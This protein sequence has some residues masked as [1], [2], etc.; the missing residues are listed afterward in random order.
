MPDG[1]SGGS[2]PDAEQK[3]LDKAMDEYPYLFTMD[4]LWLFDR[5]FPGAPRVARLIK[6][7]HV[8]IRVKSDIPL[9]RV[10][11]LL[12]RSWLADLA[13]GEGKDRVTVR[14]RVIEYWVAVEGQDVPEMFCLIT[15]LLDCEAYP[16]R[17]LAVAYRWRWNG[18]EPGCAK[19][20]ASS[21][22]PAPPPGR[23]SAPGPRC[24]SGRNS[25]PGHWPANWSATPPT[26]Q[27]RPAR[28][29]APDSPSTPAS[30]PSPPPAA[31]PSPAS[32]RAPRLRG[33]PPPRSPPAPRDCSPP[34]DV[35][36]TSPTGTGT[37]PA[38]PKPGRHSRRHTNTPT[39]IAE[40]VLDICGQA[41]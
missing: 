36:G 9:K 14:V 5:N 10:A 15:D 30:C 37:A 31:P 6:K 4:A 38:T 16:A 19:P 40:A 23:C 34:S 18:S 2:K 39:W 17:V 13:G 27:R 21:T 12:D 11:F 33:C 25:P 22:G 28:A 24:W 1:A 35:P 32:A 8:L 26:P 41:A 3:L 20:R 29:A 7:T